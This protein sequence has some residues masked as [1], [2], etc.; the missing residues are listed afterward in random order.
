MFLC[1]RDACAVMSCKGCLRY[2]DTVFSGSDD[3]VI[4]MWKVEGGR[5][6]KSED[7]RKQPKKATELVE[8]KNHQLPVV[9]CKILFP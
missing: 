6:E 7:G 5:S 2:S 1:S 4:R 8:I 3:G 9:R